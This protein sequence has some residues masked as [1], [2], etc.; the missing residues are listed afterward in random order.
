MLSKVIHILLVLAVSF[1]VPSMAQTSDS[2]GSYPK[3]NPM[4]NP[5]YNPALSGPPAETVLHADLTPS[6]HDTP[7]AGE[8]MPVLLAQKLRRT[9]QNLS[10]ICPMKSC[11]VLRGLFP[12]LKISTLSPYRRKN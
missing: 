5:A 4:P 10:L 2:H 7:P 8:A 11:V 6:L 12:S 1:G 3:H 9:H